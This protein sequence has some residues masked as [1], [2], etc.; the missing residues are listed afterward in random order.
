MQVMLA[1][2]DMGLGATVVKAFAGS[3]AG[4]GGQTY[5]RD[6]LRTFETFY[7]GVAGVLGLALVVGSGWIGSHWLRTQDLAPA[8]VGRALRLMALALALQFP[9]TLY[10]NG[11]AGLQEQGRMNALQILGNTLRY[12]GGAAALLW[13]PDIVTFFAVQT[14]VAVVQT[15]VM[16]S[17]VWRFL[18]GA[19]ARVNTGLIRDIW[20]FSAGMAATSIGAVVM[21]NA[22]RIALSR[23]APTSELGK[24]AI[25]FS[26]TGL[27]QLGIQPFYRAFF[28][29]YAELAAAGDSSGL[30]VV[31]FRSCRL[32]AFAI[33]P[34]GVIGGLF[35]PQLLV[36]W[37]GQAD[38]TVTLILRLL[39]G[40]LTL[41]GLMWLPA[42]FQQANG[43][44]QLHAGMVAA[45]VV[46]GAPIM[47]LAIRAW[48]APGATAIWVVHGVSIMTLGLWLMHR[49][50]LPG[51]MLAWY[52]VV[53]LPPLA[54]TIPVALLSWLLMPQAMGRWTGFAWAALTGLVVA[55]A[56]AVIAARD[57]RGACP[58]HSLEGAGT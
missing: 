25:A 37:L 46:V 33:I 54:L 1:V 8:T 51:E 22:D 24:Y 4:A 14:V 43:W 18:R 3:A 20:R 32:L 36:A 7:W 42:A 34:L 44:T 12:G 21:A 56:A 19:R 13:R 31:Y 10:S 58:M 2:L 27:M 9:A 57:L 5:R 40:S 35:A 38:P 45:A 41:A 16:R 52:R 48:G 17:Q 39:L 29:R 47:I 6:L 53:V 28:P 26:A 23:M 55:A 30:R 15:L 49:R 50:L 11:L